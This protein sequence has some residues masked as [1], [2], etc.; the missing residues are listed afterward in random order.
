MATNAAWYEKANSDS[1]YYTLDHNWNGRGTNPG[2]G[3]FGSFYLTAN[4]EATLVSNGSVSQ[5]IFVWTDP[6]H[7][8][9]IFGSETL[10]TSV[11]ASG[12]ITTTTGPGNVVPIPPTVLLLGSGVL[13][14]AAIRKK[15]LINF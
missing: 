6:T 11:D 7:N 3:N 10:I 4:G 9:S 13:G 1:Y 15:N 2:T 8:H 14:L 12:N 5:D